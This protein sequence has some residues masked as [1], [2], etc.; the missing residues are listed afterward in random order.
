MDKE[1]NVFSFRASDGNVVP[2]LSGLKA[3]DVVTLL[4]LLLSLPKNLYLKLVEE[5]ERK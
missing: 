3:L 4:T 5:E 1:L 2:C